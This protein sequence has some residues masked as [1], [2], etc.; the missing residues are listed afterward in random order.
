MR[1]VFS[2][3]FG[4][5]F[6][7]FFFFDEAILMAIYKV[8]DVGAMVENIAKLDARLLAMLQSLS[9]HETVKARL[10]ELGVIR[11]TSLHTLVDD[12]KQLRDFL[13]RSEEHT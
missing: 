4:V 6:T 8:P 10:A 2:D 3:Q 1:R 11:I 12:R 7:D 13:K 5:A 9:L